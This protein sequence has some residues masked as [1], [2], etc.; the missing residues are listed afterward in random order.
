LPGS[1]DG[2][3][4]VGLIASK[5]LAKATNKK[6]WD[7]N[8]GPEGDDKGNLR[9][10]DAEFKTDGND[11]IINGKRY[12]GTGGLW[13]LVTMKKPKTGSY[14]GEDMKKYKEILISST[15]MRSSKNPQ[16]PAAN[17]GHK[18]ETFVRLIWEKYVKAPKQKAKRQQKKN[19]V[20]AFSEA[21]QMPCVNVW[22]C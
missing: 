21:I 13:E 16:R 8:F 11:M 19:R 14:D 18:W 10:G 5:Y 9:L 3:V 12:S 6:K 1:Y 7:E 22:N 15:A 4:N 17:G 20:K 2:P